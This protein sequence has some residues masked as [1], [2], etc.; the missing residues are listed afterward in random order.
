MSSYFHRLARH[1][2]L[3]IGAGAVVADPVG[4]PARSTG[5][6][7]IS[8]A[9]E[10]VEVHEEH[11][12]PALPTAAASLPPPSPGRPSALPVAPVPWEAV[13]PTAESLP[14]LPSQPAA[15]DS[16]VPAL[17]CPVD[18]PREKPH[19][20]LKD[21]ELPHQVV[22]SVL[23]WISAGPESDAVLPL[24]GSAPGNS[25]ASPRPGIPRDGSAAA[26]PAAEP[27][28]APSRVIAPAAI[29]AEP[30][31]DLQP[32]FSL[33][34]DPRPTAPSILPV[35]AVAAAAP[36]SP[37][38][39]PLATA[40][41]HVSVSIG[42]IHLRVDAP[43]PAPPPRPAAPVVVPVPAPARPVGGFSRLRRHYVL[44]H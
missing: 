6:D 32:T 1:A 9:P 44:P 41:E 4:I 42:S 13:S 26:I 18:P 11:L 31:P 8:G 34:P 40:S 33:P 3:Q 21:E 5:A 35:P 38:V 20:L 15:A 14:H 10:I 24:P 23:R 27:D 30:S 16:S 39:H 17:A 28:D 25:K 36:I 12:A 19:P 22:H 43:A 29:P 7:E 2:A 37:A